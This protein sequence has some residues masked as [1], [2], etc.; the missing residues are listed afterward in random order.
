MQIRYRWF[1]MKLPN[2]AKPLAE[3]INS[4]P[5]ESKAAYGF[6]QLVNDFGNPFYRFLWHSR[7]VV[8][9]LDSEGL[10]TY[11]QIDSLS[12]TDFSIVEID[13][14]TF[15]RVEN[16]G[17]TIRDLLNALEKLA[18]MGFSVKPVT[19]EKGRPTTLLSSV[20][21]SKIIGL[22]ITGAVLAKDLVAKMEFASKEGISLETLPTLKGIN[23]KVDAITFEMIYGGKRSQIAFISNGTVKISGELGPKLV[24]LIEEDLVAL[25]NSK[26]VSG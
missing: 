6:T 10:P 13:E 8:T 1:R 16:P 12:F 14:Q 11:E 24:S 3:L 19:F 25:S 9:K 20:D 2:Q 7:V 15:L 21:A 17:R 22:K 23:Y 26:N 18:G 5:F 4:L